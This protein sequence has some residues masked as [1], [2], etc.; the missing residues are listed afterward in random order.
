LVYVYGLYI[1]WLPIN[2]SA[3]SVKAILNMVLH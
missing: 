3:I 1:W 2:D